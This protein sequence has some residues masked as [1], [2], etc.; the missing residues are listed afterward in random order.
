MNHGPIANLILKLMAMKALIF[1]ADFKTS[2][3][4]DVVTELS[5]IL[6]TVFRTGYKLSK[7][8]SIL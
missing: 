3:P 4:T 6:K 2:A 7:I 1:I 8:I 5:C